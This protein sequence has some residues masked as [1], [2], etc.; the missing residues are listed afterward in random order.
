[1]PMPMS[2]SLR[3]HW[4]P[5]HGAW[6]RMAE[7]PPPPPASTR[8]PLNRCAKRKACVPLALRWCGRL[9][10]NPCHRASRR[11]TA[12]PRL[13]E[14]PRLRLAGHGARKRL[15]ATSLRLLD[16]LFLRSRSASSCNLATSQCTGESRAKQTRPFSRRPLLQPQPHRRRAAAEA[17]A[18]PSPFRSPHETSSCAAASSARGMRVMMRVE[19]T[20]AVAHEH[21]CTD[22]PLLD[23][24]G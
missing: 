20:R 22:C 1:M 10:R 7:R 17:A 4:L 15:A 11:R 5:S 24:V 6:T 23:F 12:R 18:R 8:R 13:R 19:V 16:L 9:H 14:A 2:P 21:R 3:H